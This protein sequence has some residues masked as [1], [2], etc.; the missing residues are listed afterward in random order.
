MISK[1]HTSASKEVDSFSGG[2]FEKEDIK[3]P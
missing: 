1:G 2:N 3:L